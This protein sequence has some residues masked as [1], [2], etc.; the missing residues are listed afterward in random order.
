MLHRW[1][2]PAC[3]TLSPRLERVWPDR[4]AIDFRVITR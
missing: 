3:T 4:P 1:L 2:L